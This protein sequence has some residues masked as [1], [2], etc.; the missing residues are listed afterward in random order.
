MQPGSFLVSEVTMYNPLSTVPWVDRIV[1]SWWNLEKLFLHIFLK[2][3]WDLEFPHRSW[4]TDGNLP[5]GWARATSRTNT[6][7]EQTT[8]LCTLEVYDDLPSSEE[9]LR[10]V[11]ETPQKARPTATDEAAGL[12]I[13]PTVPEVHEDDN[14]NE[15]KNE[16]DNKNEEPTDKPED[17]DHAGKML[18]EPERMCLCRNG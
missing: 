6:L 11:V 3:E 4:Q 5:C 16:N 12:R 18:P 10:S 15:E 1:E 17:D 9:N 8:E 14:E 7:F 13:H 2:L